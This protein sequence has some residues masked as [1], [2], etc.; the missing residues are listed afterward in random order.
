MT[1]YPSHHRIEGSQSQTQQLLVPRNHNVEGDDSME[2]EGEDA[3]C[4][5]DSYIPDSEIELNEPSDEV[6][7]AP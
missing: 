7:Q 1:F 5:P 6:M 3:S 2:D 4:I